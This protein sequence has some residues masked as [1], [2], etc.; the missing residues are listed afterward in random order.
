MMNKIF[1]LLAVLMLF[2]TLSAGSMTVKADEAVVAQIGDTTYATFTDA[3]V[4]ANADVAAEVKIELLANVTLGADVTINDNII[5]DLNKQTLDL[6]GSKLTINGSLVSNGGNVVDNSRDKVGFLAVDS[7][8]CIFAPK[9]SQIPVYDGSTGY[10]FAEITHQQQTLDMEGDDVFKLIFRPYFGSSDI[11]ALLGANGNATGVNIGIRVTWT[12]TEG[13]TQTKD[14]VYKDELVKD[15]YTNNKAFYITATGV[16]S[17]RDL[18]ITP[19]VKSN[20]SNE[21]ADISE[22][23]VAATAYTWKLFSEDFEGYNVTDY[24]IT[25]FTKT[26]TDYNKVTSSIEG[27]TDN[28]FVNVSFDNII[29]KGTV[30]Q[31]P[32]FY[33]VTGNNG[34][35]KKAFSDKGVTPG[36]TTK[37]KVSFDICLTSTDHAIDIRINGDSNTSKNYER[38]IR[39]SSNGTLIF[40]ADQTKNQTYVENEWMRFD[41]FFDFSTYTYDIYL[42]G[43]QVVK[44]GSLNNK[45]LGWVESVSTV[46]TETYGSG[47]YTMYM[48]NISIATTTV[49]PAVN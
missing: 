41:V 6:N 23:E 3:I 16:R 14:L 12:D 46:S 25:G 28:K 20:V 38:F 36:A 24:K 1:K 48:D 26:A 13:I 22:E 11:N 10:A 17:F 32:R 44:R 35:V 15:V 18:T 2:A 8:K 5:L 37:F 9:N 29:P 40:Y 34:P 27:D 42:N 21:A 39:F 45:T 49:T 31:T 19:L 7:E 47:S 33:I 30:N 4:A 43:E